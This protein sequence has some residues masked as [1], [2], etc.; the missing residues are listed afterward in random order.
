MKYD[1]V[2]VGGGPA[3]TSTALHVLQHAPAVAERMIVLEK[4]RYPRDKYCAG[5]IGGRALRLL[6]RIDV[7][8]DVP[9][10]PFHGVSL[11]MA[12]DRWV[13][14]EPDIGVI[15]RRIEFDHA[16][17]KEA[18][19]R[20]IQVRDGAAVESVETTDR[21]ARVKLAGGEV[22]E[23]RAVVGADGV[24]GPVRR[25]LGLS[26]G[27]LRAQVLELDTEIVPGDPPW[28]AIHF[29]FAFADLDG[30]AWDFPTLVDGQKMMCRGIYRILGGANGNERRK[31]D[32]QER[33]ATF[34][35]GKGLDMQR[36][37]LKP[38][39]E[40]GFEPDEPIS[41]P[42]VLLAGEA[43]GIDIAT[44]EGIAQAIQYGALA[45][46][47]LARAFHEG[48]L[49]FGDWLEHVRAA[50]LG[51]QLLRRLWC[52]YRFYGRDRPT[53]E[54]VLRATPSGLRL[55]MREFAGKPNGVETWARMAG[56]LA[57]QVLWHGPG[58]VLRV[59]RGES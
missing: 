20:G 44:G 46:A 57:S 38:F 22:L 23:T 36:Y 11:G 9:H 25:S 1:L 35:R 54:K 3:G 5:A 31:D 33:L 58:L 53:L 4:E 30:Y 26:R 17:A 16:L 34:L 56:E 49:D 37:K 51:H 39:A 29:D 55:G 27:T 2:V 19:R 47:Y 32:I 52:F 48:N 42:H 18:M 45:G 14:R 12:G 50:E 43:A 41:K 6:E 8:V 24:T 13:V 10:V 40:R 59:L 28:D 7:G 15:V 21:G